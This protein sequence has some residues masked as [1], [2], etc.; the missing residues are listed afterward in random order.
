MNWPVL[1]N[2]L[3]DFLLVVVLG[4]ILKV[5]HQ[6]NELLKVEKSLKESEISL[7]KAKIGHLRSLRAPGL[8][9]DLEQIADKYAEKKRQLGEKVKLV[10]QKVRAVEEHVKALDGES[11][12]GAAAQ[13]KAFTHYK[14]G[15]AHANVEAIRL[16]E[17]SAQMAWIVGVS[18]IE[19]QINDGIRRLIGETRTALGSAGNP[20]S[21]AEWWKKAKQEEMPSDPEPDPDF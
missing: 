21:V 18:E 3:K 16:L 10:E 14:L 13:V 6:Q 20:P 1:L 2:G 11:E 9:P 5:M 7:H 19:V 4:Y 17:K 8:A 15:Y 12:P